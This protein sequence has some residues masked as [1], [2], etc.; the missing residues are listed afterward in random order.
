[1]LIVRVPLLH[2]GDFDLSAEEEAG[3]LREATVPGPK[4]IG[5]DV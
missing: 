3:L 2:P 5:R 4:K 1:M